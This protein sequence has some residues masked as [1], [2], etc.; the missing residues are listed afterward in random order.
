M[1]GSIWHLLQKTKQNKFRN[2]FKMSWNSYK[3]NGQYS[4]LTAV[5]IL[6]TIRLLKKFLIWY[7]LKETKIFPELSAAF[8][9]WTAFQAITILFCHVRTKGHKKCIQYDLNNAVHGLPTI[10]NKEW[11][12]SIQCFMTL[13]KL[14]K[15]LL[16]LR[17]T[18]KFKASPKAISY[19]QACAAPEKINRKISVQHCK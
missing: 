13:K 15:K 5:I 8:I 12:G 19:E 2:E 3:C 11:R 4:A 17:E 18:M 10:N 6:Q 1:P 9:I 16:H 14:N 7:L